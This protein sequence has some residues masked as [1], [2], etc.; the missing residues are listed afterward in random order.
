[1]HS[2]HFAGQAS[3]WVKRFAPLI[4]VG[5]VLDLA[6]GTGRHATLLAGLGHAVLAVDRDATALKEIVH[7]RIT[8]LQLEL[9][10]GATDYAGWPFEPNRFSGVVVTN[11]LHRPL[12]A[13]ILDSLAPDGVL[14]YETFAMG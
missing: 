1:M 10:A 12:F 4:P 8:T 6:C 11:Y 13:N 9:E 3:S 5:E 2:P 14:I 7:E